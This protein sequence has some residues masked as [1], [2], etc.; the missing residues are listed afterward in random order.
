MSYYPEI[1]FYLNYLNF[2]TDP[3]DWYYTHHPYHYS[4][5]PDTSK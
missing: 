1:P 2:E 3:N 4:Y 5:I